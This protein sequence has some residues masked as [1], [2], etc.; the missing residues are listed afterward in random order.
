MIFV[1]LVLFGSCHFRV[2]QAAGKFFCANKD[3]ACSL[4]CI[5]IVHRRRFLDHETPERE[6]GD[7]PY[8]QL[9]NHNIHS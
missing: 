5:H 2:D 7:P 4:F 6:S 9:E 1:P 8:E 3:V